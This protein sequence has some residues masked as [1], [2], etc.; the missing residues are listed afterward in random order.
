MLAVRAEKTGYLTSIL[1]AEN[2]INVQP[3]FLGLV[4]SGFALRVKQRHIG[5]QRLGQQL[6]AVLFARRVGVVTLKGFKIVRQTDH[7]RGN[8]PNRDAGKTQTEG[9]WATHAQEVSAPLACVW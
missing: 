9:K 3:A 1:V 6:D 7:G 8:E 2:R 5:A 4:Y